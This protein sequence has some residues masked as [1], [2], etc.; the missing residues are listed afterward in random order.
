[1]IYDIMFYA[2]EAFNDKN[3]EKGYDKNI[4]NYVDVMD[5]YILLIYLVLILIYYILNI[6]YIISNKILLKGKTKFIIFIII[7]FIEFMYYI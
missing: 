6:L 5:N 7:L 1:M 3:F 2:K 4:K